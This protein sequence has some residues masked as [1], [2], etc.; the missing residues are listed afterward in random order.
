MV[1]LV[2]VIDSSVAMKDEADT[3]NQAVAA[4]IETAKTKCPSTLRVTHLGVE[5]TFKN[6]RFDTTVKNHLTGTAKAD[7]AALRGRKKGSVA[8]G[9]AQE[10]GAR[11]IED[12]T[13]PLTGDPAPSARSSSWATRHSRAAAA[14]STT[15][16]STP[17]T[18][19]SPP[20]SRARSVQGTSRPIV[21]L[22]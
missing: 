15:T 20:P 17:P 8:G 16:I 3:L 7:E 11:A 13:A 1:N 5:G 14:T 21:R 4:A 22:T 10:D 2:V 6:T 9:G 19:P 12:V 18:A